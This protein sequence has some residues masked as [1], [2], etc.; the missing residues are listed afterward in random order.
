MNLIPN[1]FLIHPENSNKINTKV[2]ISEKNENVN[3]INIHNSER[4]NNG[5]IDRGI[6]EENNSIKSNIIDIEG[7]KTIEM[8]DLK[9][10]IEFL[11]EKHPQSDF[12]CLLSNEFMKISCEEKINEI[13]NLPNPTFLLKLDVNDINNYYEEFPIDNQINNN[14]QIKIVF[15]IY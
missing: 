7:K 2:K 1:N 12:F 3:N 6:D 10:I 4:I 13:N 8:K 5:K 14:E 11:A 9:K 15:I